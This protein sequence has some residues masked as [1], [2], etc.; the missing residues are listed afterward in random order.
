V[1]NDHITVES[2]L[3]IAGKRGWAYDADGRYGSKVLYKGRIARAT[4]G[5]P[6]KLL[7]DEIAVKI[8][9]MVPRACFEPLNLTDAGLVEVPSHHIFSPAFFTEDPDDEGGE[10]P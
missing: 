10:E 1:S 3:V 4:V 8:T 6:S 7:R 5:K 9:L 2:Y